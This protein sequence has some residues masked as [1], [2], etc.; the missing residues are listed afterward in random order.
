MDALSRVRDSLAS[1][2]PSTDQPCFLL[3]LPVELRIKIYSYIVI[4]RLDCRSH[5]RLWRPL[6]VDGGIHRIGYFDRGTVIPLLL[7]SHQVHDEAAAVLY[8]EITFAFHISGLAEGPIAFLERLHPKYI[9][10]LRRVYIQTGYHVDPYGFRPE[11]AVHDRGYVEPAAEA[12][13]IKEARD[14]AVSVALMKQAW[15]PK[16]SVFINKQ[17]T[18]SYSADNAQGSIPKDKANDWPASRFHLWK[19]FVTEPDTE[20]PRFEFRRIK[21][22]G[23]S[24]RNLRADGTRATVPWTP[25]I[26]N[27]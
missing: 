4:S 16:Y 21:W 11:P 2:S 20:R 3:D 23:P 24:V 13:K 9:R 14:L 7:T 17:A 10:L 25:V 6:G 18:V 27:K 19:M 12:V 1:S 15:P 22:G 8:G 26:K 5:P